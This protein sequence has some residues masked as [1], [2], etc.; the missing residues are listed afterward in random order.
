MVQG[1]YLDESGPGAIQYGSSAVNE[2]LNGAM[3]KLPGFIV[4]LEM[5]KDGVIREF[6]LVPYFGACIHVPPPPPNQ[7][8]FVRMKQGIS[9]D[10]IYDAQWITGRLKTSVYES[11]MASAAYTLDG[12]KAEIYKD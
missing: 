12:D 3:V 1:D 6:L 5:A 7:I 4:P 8:V 11:Q 2:K 9:M 10:S